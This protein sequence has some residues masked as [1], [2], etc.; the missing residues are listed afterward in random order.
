MHIA[1]KDKD[2][3]GSPAENLSKVSILFVV[4][5]ALINKC[6]VYPP[7]AL[8][9]ERLPANHHTGRTRFGLA[10][11][12]HPLI[13]I[14]EIGRRHKIAGSRI[15][16]CAGISD[17]ELEWTDVELRGGFARIVGCCGPDALKN[18]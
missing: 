11:R 12:D 13:E 16:V 2:R 10:K 7:L 3:A 14:C 18:C 5:Q 8:C 17:K 6:A 9:E 1:G 15:A 4:C